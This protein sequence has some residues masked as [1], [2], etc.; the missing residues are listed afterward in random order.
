MCTLCYIE[1]DE[2]YVSATV[3]K[4]LKFDTVGCHYVIPQYKD[5]LSKLSTFARVAVVAAPSVRA[6]L[7]RSKTQSSVL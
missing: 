6:D 1:T 5:K 7:E 3:P 4:S 2:R